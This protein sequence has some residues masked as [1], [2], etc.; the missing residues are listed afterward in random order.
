MCLPRGKEQTVVRSAA[1]L[2]TP[3][4]PNYGNKTFSQKLRNYKGISIRV[5]IHKARVSLHANTIPIYGERS[6]ALALGTGNGWVRF[7]HQRHFS[8]RF[9]L[10]GRPPFPHQGLTH[11]APCVRGPFRLCL[12]RHNADRRTE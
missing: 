5:L 10:L 9:C 2:R 12:P 11:C 7:S 8:P 4:R 1:T 3:T 6:A